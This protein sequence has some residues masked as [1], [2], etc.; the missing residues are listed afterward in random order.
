[1]GLGSLV[2]VNPRT[3]NEELMVAMATPQG[4]KVL[5]NLKTFPTLREAVEPYQL[6]VG[7]TARPGSRRGP[8][9]TPRQLAPTLLAEDNPRVA[10]VFGP[11]RMGLSTSDLRLCQKIVRVPTD[12]P[13]ASSLNLAQAVLIFGYELLL[14]AEGP[15][16]PPSPVKAA[17]QINLNEMYD[18][19]ESTLTKIGFLPDSNS[20]HWLMN[21][22]KIFNRSQL[23]VGEC[24]LFRGICRQIRWAVNNLTSLK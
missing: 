24:D 23:T 1:M 12:N 16:P 6:V 20:G 15:T 14:A 17:P 4:A 13:Q 2:L 11:E 7:T 3:L 19:L 22:K 21:I 9:L 18:D 10:L 5:A 8:L